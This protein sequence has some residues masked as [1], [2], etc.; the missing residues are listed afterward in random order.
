MPLQVDAV[1][2]YIIG[3]NTYELTKEDLSIDSPYNTYKYKGLPF[4]R[5][6]ILELVQ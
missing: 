6:Q 4:G 1:F 2:P 5:Y 3:K